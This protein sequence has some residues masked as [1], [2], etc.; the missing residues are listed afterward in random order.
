M[1]DQAPAFQPHKP[2]LVRWIA[3]GD[4]DDDDDYAMSMGDANTNGQHQYQWAT[5]TPTL[6]PVPME[7]VMP[8]T[9]E[10]TNANG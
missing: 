3:G 4:W 10:D 2:L 7:D 9:V 6:T 5:P 8:T 1:N